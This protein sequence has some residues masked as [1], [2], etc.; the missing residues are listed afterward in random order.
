MPRPS[1]SGTRCFSAAAREPHAIVIDDVLCFRQVQRRAAVSRPH[2]PA[3]A[4]AEIAA[5]TTGGDFA[6][7]TTKSGTTFQRILARYT[8][9]NIR[10][11]PS[12]VF[13]YSSTQV[14]LGVLLDDNEFRTPLDRYAEIHAEVRDLL[15]RG[16]AR[17]RQVER[18]VGRIT[19]RMLLLRL[20]LSVFDAV[21]A[22]ARKVGDRHARLWPAVAAELA[23]VA[24][25]AADA[26]AP[27]LADRI[28]SYF[29]IRTLRKFR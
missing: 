26:R 20:T 15:R 8:D 18:L 19:S 28:V 13:D 7:L 4:A 10:T 1:P 29:A 23:G 6:E 21:Y 11:K 9:V 25:L 5:A 14:G 24:P 2:D 16:W 17:P 27:T 22:F 3:V 12:K